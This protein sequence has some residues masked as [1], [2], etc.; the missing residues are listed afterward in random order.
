MYRHMLR[1]IRRFY[2]VRATQVLPSIVGDQYYIWL[3]RQQAIML[4]RQHRYY[5]ISLVNNAD[6]D[7][8]LPEKFEYADRQ[9]KF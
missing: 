6:G 8:A 3:S 7:L 4:T 2:K 5:T 9:P 1:S